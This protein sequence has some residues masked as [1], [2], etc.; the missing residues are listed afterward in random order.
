MIEM[1]SGKTI[2]PEEIEAHYQ[3]S[4]FVEEVCVMRLADPARP[5]AERLCAAVVPA[6]DRVRA[7]K[8]VNVGDIIRFEMEGLTAAIPEHKR[9]LGY[10]I[11]FE[12]LPRTPAQTIDREQVEQRT[13]Q[14]RELT[15]PG[16]EVAI[17]DADRQ[18]MEEPRAAA[19]L[20][21]IRE[22]I[23]QATRL[24]PD[25]NLEID[26]GFDSMSRVELLTELEQRYAV[27]LPPETLCGILTVRHLAAAL[28]AGTGDDRRAGMQSA[29]VRGWSLLLRDLPPATDPVLSGLLEKRLIAAPLMHLAARMIRALLF[30]VELS[31]LE[32]LPKGG[33]YLICPNHQSYLDPFMICPMLPFRMFRNLFF[34][35]A[36]EYFETPLTQWFARLANLVPVDPDSNLVPAMQA[37]AFGLAHGKT[38]VLFPEGERSIDGTVKKFK[39]GA[40]ILAQHMHVP[41]VPVAINGVFEL[42]PRGQGFN[43]RLLRP[44]SR[45]RVRIVIGEPMMF[46]EDADY[47]RTATQLRDRVERM[48][49][50][51]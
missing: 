14:R 6:M 20:A 42:W 44:W 10:D 16:R 4:A 46:A 27:R 35:G 30:R 38:L 21:V 12:P 9:V 18:W 17:N 11:W 39:K 2:D 32:N 41:I 26:L 45:H 48:W 15:S 5:G 25:A 33:A 49:L 29:N 47:N 13:R 36:V 28:P 51:L 7:K 8:I 19:V 43:W 50:A 40:P 37:G 31:G 3:Q 1:S 23:G 24:H 34:V 22:R